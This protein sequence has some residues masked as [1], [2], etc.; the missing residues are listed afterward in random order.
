MRHYFLAFILFSII[1]CSKYVPLSYLDLADYQSTLDSLSESIL[2][3]Y[4]NKRFNDKVEQ[5]YFKSISFSK[6]KFIDIENS[7]D[8]WDNIFV[9]L[10]D[11]Y[12]I[13][14]RDTFPSDFPE[15][16]VFETIIEFFCLLLN[17]KKILCKY[18]RHRL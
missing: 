11:P 18:Q 4:D 12:L 8:M 1:S 15:F 7:N 9:K 5:E 17:R 14:L 6:A 13:A 2:V 16:W 10:K 3:K